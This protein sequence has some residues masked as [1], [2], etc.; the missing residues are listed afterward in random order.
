MIPRSLLH[1]RSLSFVLPGYRVPGIFGSFVENFF[2][3]L[4]RPKG[5]NHYYHLRPSISCKL[6]DSLISLISPRPVPHV[7]RRNINESPPFMTNVR[8]RKVVVRLIFFFFFFRNRSLRPTSSRNS[9]SFV[10]PSLPRP[11]SNL[12]HS[13]VVDSDTSRT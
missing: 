3:V 5:R 1:I 2:I 7:R 10:Y 13:Q 12:A 11:W 4:T 6:L 9:V 8:T